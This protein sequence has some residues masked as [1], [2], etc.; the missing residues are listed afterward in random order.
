MDV[1]AACVDELVALG[2]RLALLGSGD[3]ALETAFLAAAERH[4]G[5]VCV[6]I[7]YDEPLSHLLQGGADAILIPSRFEPCGLT[8]LYGLA[9][10][11]VP[12]VA[13][14]GGLADTIIDANT[15]ALAA[16]V[17]TGIQFDGVTQEALS[18]ALRRAVALYAD[19]EGWQCLQ[20]R[21]M[22]ADFSWET[23]GALYAALYR[24]LLD[25]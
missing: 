4:P 25:A 10:G 18:D 9:Y 5:R 8:Q 23:S 7:G 19:A 24:K 17:A 14:T 20:R 13:R 6:R 12:I 11:C 2:G 22:K 3:R 21:G 1:L 16:G 15:A